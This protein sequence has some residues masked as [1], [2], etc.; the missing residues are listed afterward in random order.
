MSYTEDDYRFRK[1]TLKEGDVTVPVKIRIKTTQPILYMSDRSIT[2]KSIE[3]YPTTLKRETLE[4][5]D[6]F[7]DA[8]DVDVIRYKYL[9]TFREC[10]ANREGCVIYDRKLKDI[11]VIPN[12]EEVNMVSWR[13]MKN[14]ILTGYRIGS[15]IVNPTSNLNRTEL[16]LGFDLNDMV[17]IPEPEQ[18]SGVSHLIDA[19]GL[20]PGDS[21]NHYNNVVYY[22]RP[23][24]HNDIEVN[25]GI[26]RYQTDTTNIIELGTFGDLFPSG[27]GAG[28]PIYGVNQPDLCFYSAELLGKFVTPNPTDKL[29]ILMDI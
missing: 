13:N 25:F 4:I 27:V 19:Y 10:S 14:D 5:I 20:Q 22:E 26:Q 6:T 8:S 29:Y 17:E 2:M 7:K 24:L 28:I 18:L 3:Q 23:K 9:F 12:I 1:M 21:G 16:S 15:G 11:I